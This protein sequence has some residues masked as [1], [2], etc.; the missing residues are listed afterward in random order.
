MIDHLFQKGVLFS[1]SQGQIGSAI[2]LDC[3]AA[4]DGWMCIPAGPEIGKGQRNRVSRCTFASIV[5]KL[6]A[7]NE[8]ARKVLGAKQEER[9]RAS[10]HGRSDRRL[11]L[12]PGQ[13]P[14]PADQF[15]KPPEFHGTSPRDAKAQPIL[16]VRDELRDLALPVVCSGEADKDFEGVGNG[17]E[18]GEGTRELCG[19]DAGLGEI[20]YRLV[21]KRFPFEMAH[22]L[23]WVLVSNPW[24]DEFEVPPVL[25]RD[26]F[27]GG[28]EG[29]K[30]RSRRF[31]LELGKQRAV[32]FG[33]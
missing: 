25:F 31:T 8:I 9:A 6:D 22:D 13:N 20:P 4:G 10:V 24:L 30:C 12:L 27:E 29:G 19:F 3:V 23:V 15:I 33:R 11:V 2:H 28:T 17:T 7:I 18:F 32:D 16:Q 5:G 1:S 26:L 14:A 21:G